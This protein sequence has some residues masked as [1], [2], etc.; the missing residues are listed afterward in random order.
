MRNIFKSLLFKYKNSLF[1]GNLNPDGKII[2]FSNVSYTEKFSELGEKTFYVVMV[3]Q[4]E[5]KFS[6]TTLDEC[7]MDVEEPKP[8]GEL[9][10]EE[11]FETAND[12]LDQYN[13]SITLH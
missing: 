4:D 8:I 2:K 10:N 11:L 3:V 13:K 1:L 6:L 9:S 7:L 12:V 5:N